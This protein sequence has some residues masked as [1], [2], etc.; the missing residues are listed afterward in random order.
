[1]DFAKEGIMVTTQSR[2]RTTERYPIFGNNAYS[3]TNEDEEEENLQTSTLTM[4][5]YNNSFTTTTDTEPAFEI[6]KEYNSK[7][8]EEQEE[9]RVV[10]PAMQQVQR[11]QVITQTKS[12]TKLSP[13]LKIMITVYSLVVALLIGFAI[14]NAVA[15][16]SGTAILASKQVE[17]S[18]SAEVINNLQAQ[19]NELGTEQAIKDQVSGEFIEADSSNTI[20]VAR[21][22]LDVTTSYQAPTNWFDK[23]CE[24][25][26]SLF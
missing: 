19:Y 6:E 26:S 2:T 12:A 20:I 25:F 1:M 10:T 23:I 3:P 4:P 24:F 15:I 5:S 8:E 22:E 18:A 11:K 14:Y 17:V 7:V 9:F 13:R 16:S 21:P